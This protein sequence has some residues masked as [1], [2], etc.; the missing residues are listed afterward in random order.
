[1]YFRKLIVATGVSQ[2]VIPTISGAEFM[3]GYED[4]S[5]DRDD[6]EGQTVL[7]LG[8]VDIS[9]SRLSLKL[10]TDDRF[11]YKTIRNVFSCDPGQ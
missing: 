11:G 9:N 8:I 7:I 1:M 5:L 4:M 3:D 10:I 2:P 6:Y